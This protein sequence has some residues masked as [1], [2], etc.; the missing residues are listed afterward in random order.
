MTPTHCWYPDDEVIQN[1][2]IYKM[3]LQNGFTEYSDFWNWSAQQKEDFWG[4]TIDNLGIRFKTRYTNLLNLSRGEENAQW[5]AGSKLN[6]VDSCFQNDDADT[7]LVYQHEGGELE[8]LS[9]QELLKLV[10]RVGNSLIQQGLKAGDRIAVDMPMTL[11]AVCIYLGA[12]KAGLAVVTIADSFSDNEIEVRLKITKPKLVFTQD[13]LQRAGKKLPMYEKVLRANPPKTIV[14]QTVNAGPVLR[15]EDMH[16]HEFL[17]DNDSLESYPCSPEDDI[18][19]LFSSGTTGEPKAIPWNHVTPIKGASDGYY[20]H[21][22]HKGDVVCWPTN[23]G[24][25]MGPWL[26]FATLINKGCLTLY[27]GAPT[28]EGFGR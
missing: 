2:N 19:V 12:I 10:N 8:S 7:A 21:D 25:M 17:S 26:I 28:G 22:I 16:Y 6:I 18:T 15:A 24:W 11:E 23:L 14:V 5:L 1:S 13:V 20:H 9:Q 4:Q 3:M 27:Y